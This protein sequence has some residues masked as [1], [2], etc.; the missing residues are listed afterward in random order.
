M[1]TVKKLTLTPD[2]LL[3]IISKF[4]LLDPLSQDKFRFGCNKIGPVQS[5]ARQTAG[6]F[7]TSFAS[8]S[9]KND[10]RDTLLRFSINVPSHTTHKNI[11]RN[12]AGRTISPLEWIFTFAISRTSIVQPKARL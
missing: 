4:R 9:E 7:R 10:K 6:S 11:D 5:P 12:S 2:P 3:A 8:Q 1:F